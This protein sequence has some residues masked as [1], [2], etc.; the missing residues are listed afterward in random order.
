MNLA[1]GIEASRGGWGAGR[2]GGGCAGINAV[3]NAPDRKTANKGAESVLAR[4]LTR[5]R[6]GV[7]NG[8]AIALR[9]GFTSIRLNLRCIAAERV[10]SHFVLPCAQF[11][12][13]KAEGS[14]YRCDA[15]LADSFGQSLCCEQRGR[16]ANDLP[17]CCSPIAVR[18]IPSSRCIA[19]A[20][21]SGPRAPHRHSSAPPAQQ[22]D[23]TAPD[24]GGPGG[25]NGAIALPKR[26]EK[27]EERLRRRRLSPSSRIRKELETIRC[28][29][30]CPK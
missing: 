12:T 29:L 16:H 1:E 7:R 27:P 17:S 26:K 28:G 23:Q 3:R 18:F 11:L 6:T 14:F 9:Q 22:P 10:L 21:E 8:G 4:A 25:D 2:H 19:L 5:D 15:S 13:P 30:R 24:A 20:A